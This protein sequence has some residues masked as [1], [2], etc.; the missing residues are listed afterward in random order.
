MQLFISDTYEESVA[1]ELRNV[2][3]SDDLVVAKGSRGMR[4]ER[5]VK[6]LSPNSL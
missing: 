4:V 3:G 2:V 5:F 6:F 1:S